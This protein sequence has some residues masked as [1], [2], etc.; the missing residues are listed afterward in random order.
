MLHVRHITF[1]KIKKEYKKTTTFHGRSS[2][3]YEHAERISI[4]LF[5]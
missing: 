1:L 5:L 4:G 2:T 3:V